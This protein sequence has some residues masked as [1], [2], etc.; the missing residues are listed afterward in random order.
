MTSERSLR[1][2]TSATAKPTAFGVG[3]KRQLVWANRRELCDLCGLF[4]IIDN[5]LSLSRYDTR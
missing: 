3:G 2:M 1:V 5:D 4:P